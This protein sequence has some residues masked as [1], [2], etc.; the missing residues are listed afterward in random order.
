[1]KTHPL[2]I[3]ADRVETRETAD[4]VNPY[5]GRAIARVHLAGP[6]GVEKAIASA[7]RAFEVTRGQSSYAVTALLRRAA[8]GI[9]K[10]R[11]RLVDSIVAEAGKPAAGRPRGGPFHHHLLRRRRGGQPAGRR[12]FA[13]GH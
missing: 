2:I 13:G 8:E 11:A 12:V 3:G 10:H 5:T 9:A 6:A 7:A 1:M 4:V